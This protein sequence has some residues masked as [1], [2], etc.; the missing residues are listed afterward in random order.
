MF[1]RPG[2]GIFEGVLVLVKGGGK[3]VSG[4]FRIFGRD[5]DVFEGVK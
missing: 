1:R 5:E 2:K 3:G 4:S